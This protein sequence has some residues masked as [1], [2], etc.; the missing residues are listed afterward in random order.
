[1]PPSTQRNFENMLFAAAFNDDDPCHPN[2][3]ALVNC[4]DS[5]GKKVPVICIVLDNEEGTYYTP[6][7]LMITSSF[8][9]FLNELK[10]PAKLK[11]NWTW[12]TQTII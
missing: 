10:P 5:K 9:P 4:T 6:Y 12:D 8:A 3:L 1:M 11:G 2:G 7:A